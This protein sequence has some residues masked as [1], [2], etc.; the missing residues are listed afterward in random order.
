VKSLY[1]AYSSL[2]VGLFFCAFAGM[3]EKVFAGMAPLCLFV[4]DSRMRGNYHF[5]GAGMKKEYAQQ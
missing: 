1:F 2:F 4:L 3:K 5:G